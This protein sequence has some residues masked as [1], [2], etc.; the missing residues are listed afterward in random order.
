MSLINRRFGI[1]ALAAVTLL[2]LTSLVPAQGADH[3][4]EDGGTSTRHNTQEPQL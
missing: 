2:L 3:I 4:M 1:I